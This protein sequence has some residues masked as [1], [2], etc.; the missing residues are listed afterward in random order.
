QLRRDEAVGHE[1]EHHGDRPPREPRHAHAGGGGQGVDGEDGADGEEQQVRAPQDPREE[2][3]QALRLA[4]QAEHPEEATMTTHAQELE[5]YRAQTRNS[6][7]LYGRAERVLPL[8]VSSNFRTYEPYP[9]YIERAQ[10]SRMW[11]R[12]GREYIDCSMCF[13]AMMVGHAHPV[14]VEAIARAAGEA[15]LYAMPHDR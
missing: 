9:I 3:R 8:G 7:E 15:T 14:M 1:E 2:V 13:G 6:H 11:D 10:G 12:D 4:P 5:R